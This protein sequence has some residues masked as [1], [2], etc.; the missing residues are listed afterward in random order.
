M[1][2]KLLRT[3][4]VT[5]EV[6]REWLTEDGEYTEEEGWKDVEEEIATALGRYRFATGSKVDF[7]EWADDPKGG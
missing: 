2:T 7:S 6:P 4:A 1:A 3:A 5:V